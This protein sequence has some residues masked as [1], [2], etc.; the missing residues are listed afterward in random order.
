[1]PERGLRRVELLEE[2]A[3]DGDAQARELGVE[4]L[5]GIGGWRGN[6]PVHGGR[7][8]WFIQVN[9]DRSRFIQVNHG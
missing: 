9:Q 4:R 8:G 6:R 1:M 2:A 3:G 5:H 7:S